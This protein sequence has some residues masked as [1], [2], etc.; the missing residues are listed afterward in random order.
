MVIED[1]LVESLIFATWSLRSCHQH[2]FETVGKARVGNY[3]QYAC[4]YF[5]STEN[6]KSF[7]WFTL[8]TAF[9]QCTGIIDRLKL[10]SSAK[11]SQRLAM[12]IACVVDFFGLKPNIVF[13]IHGSYAVMKRA[14]IRLAR[15][16]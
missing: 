15:S 12:N 2:K 7:I 4:W 11:S 16:L 9:S 3:L 14:R 10:C 8:S 6:L 1:T 13:C 5:Q